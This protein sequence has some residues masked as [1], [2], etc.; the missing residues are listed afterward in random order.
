MNETTG[1]TQIPTAAA[2]ASQGRRNPS[3]QWF[4]NTCHHATNAPEATNVRQ[5]AAKNANQYAPVLLMFRS[6]ATGRANARPTLNAANSRLSVVS[7]K[8]KDWAAVNAWTVGGLVVAVKTACAITC[9][10]HQWFR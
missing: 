2:T 10:R 3:G 1:C 6:V 5:A 4:S 9:I 7:S 8:V